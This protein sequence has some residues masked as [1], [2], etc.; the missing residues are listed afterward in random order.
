M[1]G[2]WIQ[3][4][5][6]AITGRLRAA[7]G[8]ARKYNSAGDECG[9][10]S[11]VRH[12]TSFWQ[13]EICKNPGRQITQKGKQKRQTFQV[14]SRSPT[15]TTKD[16]RNSADSARAEREAGAAWVVVAP[17]SIGL[18]APRSASPALT[19]SGV[20]RTQKLKSPLFRTQSWEMFSF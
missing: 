19:R 8:S 4:L 12:L 6:L 20:L 5:H 7:F 14:W 10:H 13:R 18:S 11:I 3:P 17:S 1:L 9:S 15:T 16:W 2:V